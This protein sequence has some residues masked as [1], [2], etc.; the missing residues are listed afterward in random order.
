MNTDVGFTAV[1]AKNNTHD[2][3][4]ARRRHITGESA[5]ILPG[6]G[7]NMFF[8]LRVDG[9]RRGSE[10]SCG[11]GLDLDEAKNSAVPADEVDLASVVGDAKVR[12]HNLV[13][14]PPQVEVS[15]NFTPLAGPK[16]LWLS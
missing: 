11:S 2:I 8:L 12:R 1:R 5:D 4:A 7:T 3:E 14:E 15:L 9:G 16:V 6:N 13:S 10:I